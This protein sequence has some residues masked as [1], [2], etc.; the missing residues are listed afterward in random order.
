MKKDRLSSLLLFVLICLVGYNIFFTK[1]LRTD[2]ESYNQ[3]IDS[4]QTNIDSVMIVNKELDE[5]INKINGEV[6]V[7]DNNI[8]RVQANIKNIKVETNEK[9]NAVNEF[10]F[11]DLLKFFT[12]RYESED[13]SSG[14]D[15]SSKSS[16]R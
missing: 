4:I 5:H 6:T 3:K 8:D 16:N 2:V 11:S 7:L 10:S 14:Y 15:S 9:V 13:D 1:Q 12:N